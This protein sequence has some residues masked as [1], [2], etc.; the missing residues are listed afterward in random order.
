MKSSSGFKAIPS[1][2]ANIT[3]GRRREISPVKKVSTFVLII[4]V[5]NSEKGINPNGAIASELV[6]PEKSAGKIFQAIRPAVAVST[7]EVIIPQPREYI[8]ALKA[9]FCLRKFAIPDVK[10]TNTKGIIM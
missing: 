3:T 7:R 9:C 6:T 1:R 2:S 10:E 8:T 4:P 5:M